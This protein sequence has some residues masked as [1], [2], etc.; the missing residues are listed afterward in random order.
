MVDSGIILLEVL[1]RGQPRR[2]DPAAGEPH[3]RPPQDLE[4]L[5][6]GPQVL[7]PLVRLLAGP[8]R[9]C[10]RPPT[11]SWAPWFV[12]HTDD[13][14]RGRLNIITHLLSQIP[15]EPLEAQ[16]GQAAQAAGGRRLPRAGSV[17]CATSRR[18]SD[19]DRAL[20]RRHP[21]ARRRRRGPARRPG[22]RAGCSATRSSPSPRISSAGCRPYRSW[23][24]DVIVIGTRIL[25][26]GR[27]RRRP[28]LDP[29]P[30]ALA[31][32]AHRRG[33]PAASPPLLVALVEA[34]RA[35]RRRIDARRRRRR[36]RDR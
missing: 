10:S 28:D 17:R 22:H 19:R 12:A 8:G 20:P 27:A 15:Y 21:A 25:G 36:P 33:S 5:R 30:S 35:G 1:A 26:R 13:K 2:A 18:R 31:D 23:I 11:P 6:H 16:A 32:A 7:Q 3:R 4:A 34:G 14:K 9:R 29:R 24:I